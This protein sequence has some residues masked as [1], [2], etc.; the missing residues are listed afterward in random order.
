[1]CVRQT[2]KHS[3]S[4]GPIGLHDCS[5]HHPISHPRRHRFLA[6]L[7]PIAMGHYVSGILFH[8]VSFML[9]VL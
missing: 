2:T 7:I 3:F 4:V 9:F 1:M 6:F 5:D 8:D